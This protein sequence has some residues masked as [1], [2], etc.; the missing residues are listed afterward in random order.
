VKF[1]AVV[2]QASALLHS[3][4]HIT[5]MFCDLVEST[6]LSE[7]LDPKEYH[8]VVSLYQETCT[9]VIRRYA[10]H[11]AQHLGDGLLAYFGYPVAHEED[12]Q[13]AVRTGL[14]ILVALAP[15]DARR[16]VFTRSPACWGICEGAT[17]QHLRFFLVKYRYS[18]YPQG[19]ASYT[20]CNVLP[21]ACSLRRSLLM[22]PCRVPIV[23]RNTTSASRSAATYA[24]AIVSLWTSRPMKSV[25][26]CATAD[27]LY[28]NDSQSIMRL[29]PRKG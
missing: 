5:Y 9:A 26:A 20:K 18:Q 27:L 25:L 14:E 7:Q 6:A 29:W 15:L 13:R 4:S 22:S 17:T 10:G 23:L 2:N 1:S 12:A 8:E 28:S 19:Q 16:W 21:F 24:T 3:K 11:I